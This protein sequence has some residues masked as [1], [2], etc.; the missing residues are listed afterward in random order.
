M[1]VDLSVFNLHKQP[2]DPFDEPIEVDMIQE[3]FEEFL[4]DES[5]EFHPSYF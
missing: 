5:L 1:T 3:L 4:I 2:T